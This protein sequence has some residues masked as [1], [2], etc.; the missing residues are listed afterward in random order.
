MFKGPKGGRVCSQQAGQH[1]EHQA[2][3]L[4]LKHPVQGLASLLALL[5]ASTIGGVAMS[6]R[7][8]KRSGRDND[9]G[10]RAAPAP[11]SAEQQ[12]S[13]DDT[14]VA[15]G[16]HST[17]G[18]GAPSKRDGRVSLDTNTSAGHSLAAGSQLSSTASSAPDRT[19]EERTGAAAA[20]AVDQQ[21]YRDGAESNSKRGNVPAAIHMHGDLAQPEKPLHSLAHSEGSEHDEFVPGDEAGDDEGAESDSAG[22]DDQAAD[23]GDAGALSSMRS[24]HISE[25]GQ[26]RWVNTSD[27][28]HEGW[29][30]RNREG[31]QRWVRASVDGIDVSS[32]QSSH[33]T[34]SAGASTQLETVHSEDAARPSVDAASPSFASFPNAQGPRESVES[35][36]AQ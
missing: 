31:R 9:R 22:S 27:G 8:R 29:V 26:Q 36:A 10:G 18:L 16:A 20:A 35:F 32:P 5:T 1:G 25:G 34:A 19:D 7:R 4:S 30:R 13:A 15:E 11:R 3:Q 2:L 21:V 12:A 14:P 33:S 28:R 6:R 23:T 17:D 24:A